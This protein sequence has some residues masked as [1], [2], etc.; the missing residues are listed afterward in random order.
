MKRSESSFSSIHPCSSSSLLLPFHPL[1]SPFPDRCGRPLFFLFSSI[2]VS[3]CDGV[4]LRSLWSLLFDVSPKNLALDSLRGLRFC[5]RNAYC[6]L[7]LIKTRTQNNQRAS[8]INWYI[9]IE[10]QKKTSQSSYLLYVIIIHGL[11]F[12]SILSR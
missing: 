3:K 6:N 8:R 12:P 4:F 5:L 10:Q 9:L 11:Q 1:G 2:S 7:R